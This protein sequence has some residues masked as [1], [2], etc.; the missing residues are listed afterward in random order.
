M[1]A[2]L[3]KYWTVEFLPTHSQSLMELSRAVHSHLHC[4][5]CCCQISSAMTMK[6]TSAS[7]SDSSLMDVFQPAEATVPK[8]KWKGIQC[9]ALLSAD[10]STLRCS[11][12]WTACNNFSFTIRTQKAEIMY[13]PSLQKSYAE[14]TI[15]IVEGETLKVVDESLYLTIKLS[16]TSGTSWIRMGEK[17]L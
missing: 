11:G 9:T 6:Q 3:L 4:S 5:A 1:V 12:V 13:E 14:P 10:E 16:R 17:R 2:C 15:I 7:A 8:P